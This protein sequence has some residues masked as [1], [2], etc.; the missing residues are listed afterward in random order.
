MQSKQQN[1]S[2]T[3]WK[4]LSQEATLQSDWRSKIMIYSIAGAVAHYT[5]LAF[6]VFYVVWDD[7]HQPDLPIQSIMGT[8]LRKSFKSFLQQFY[9]Y[10]VKLYIFA[11]REQHKVVH[12]MPKKVLQ[13]ALALGGWLFTVW[14]SPHM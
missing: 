6:T 2:L 7:N 11:Y 12:Y 4:Y 3:V 14:P 9:L 13:F 1:D 10:I 5:L 8:V